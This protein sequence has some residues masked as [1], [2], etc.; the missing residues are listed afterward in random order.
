MTPQKPNFNRG[1]WKK[2]ETKVRA[3]AKKFDETFVVSGPVSSEGCLDKLAQA[4]CVPPRF[5]KV[6]MVR[7]GSQLH[8]IG[9]V[10]PQTY[11][12]KDINPYAVSF[13]KVDDLT[14][15]DFFPNVPKEAQERIEAEDAVD[16][17]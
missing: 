11:T 5:F 1:L 13:H 12:T 8:A 16:Q 14:G 17:W 7:N 10:M 4:I 6:V 15:L 2:L 3:W 9:F